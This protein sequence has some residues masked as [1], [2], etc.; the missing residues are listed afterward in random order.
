MSLVKKTK[1]ALDDARTFML[2]AQI[3]LGF[4]LQAPFQS[5]FEPAP[6]QD[7][8]VSLATVLLMV[9]VVAF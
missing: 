8:L 2:G 6:P 1:L 9:L 4:Q 5:A 7:R 3:L